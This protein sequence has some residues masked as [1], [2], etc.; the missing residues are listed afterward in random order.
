MTPPLLRRSG[1]GKHPRLGHGLSIHPATGVTA[2]FEEEVV[3]WRGV[4]QSAGIEELHAR[5]GILLEATSTPP[6]MGAVSAPGYGAHLLDRLARA[7][8]TATLGGMI[9]DRPS[10]RVLGPSRLVA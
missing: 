6:G 3:Q 5:R 9:A 7:T 1:V 10:G 8:H 2:S 4:M